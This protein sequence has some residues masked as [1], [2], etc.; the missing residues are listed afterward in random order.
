MLGTKQ[1]LLQQC[2]KF[3]KRIRVECD[4]KVLDLPKLQ[5][6]V[7]L[8]INSYMGGTNFVSALLGVRRC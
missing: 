4:G 3:H 8:N 6:L 5:G 7:V 1:L 2:K